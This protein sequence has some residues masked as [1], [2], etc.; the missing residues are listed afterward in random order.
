[1]SRSSWRSGRFSPRPACNRCSPTTTTTWPRSSALI[2]SP[3][4]VLDKVHRYHERLGHTVLHLH[5]DTA[6]L[7]PAQHRDSLELFQA[8]VA[9][10]LR[11]TIADPPWPQPASNTLRR[12][13]F[14]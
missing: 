14:R 6:G 5:S 1:M 13:A 8:E 10:E 2:G 12:K 4:Q 9:P 11:R 3:E 7:T